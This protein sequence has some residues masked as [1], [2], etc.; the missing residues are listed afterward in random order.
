M[1]PHRRLSQLD[2]IAAQARA[3]RTGADDEDEVTRVPVEDLVESDDVE[4]V[5]S[6]EVVV[7]SD[8]IEIS[9]EPVWQANDAT[10][11]TPL[12]RQAHPTGPVIVAK[13]ATLGKVAVA[14]TPPS[15]EERKVETVPRFTIEPSGRIGVR[16]VPAAQ[17]ALEAKRGPEPT[18]PSHAGARRKVTDATRETPALD[19]DAKPS[20]RAPLVDADH[21]MTRVDLDSPG[22]KRQF[23]G[24][25]VARPV[26]SFPSVDEDTNEHEHDAFDEAAT[27]ADVP[28]IPAAKDKSVISRVVH[29]VV[30]AV[31]KAIKKAMDA[32][33]LHKVHPEG[34]PKEPTA[35]RPAPQPQ[36]INQRDWKELRTTA[37]FDGLPNEALRDALLTGELRVLRLGR[38]RLIPLDGAIGVIRAG[39]VAVGSFGADV[40]AEE[41]K[42]EDALRAAEV[43]AEKAG[44]KSKAEKAHK[45]E[46]KRRTDV[47]ALIQLADRN[48]AY[49]EEGDVV[50]TRVGA[51]RHASI[52]CYTTTPATV[53]VVGRG[54]ADLWKRIY[55]FMSDR[56]RRAAATTRARLEATDG[57]KALVADFFIRHGLSVSMT[58]RVRKIDSCIECG[59]CEQA[60]EDR[61]GAKRLSLN[62]RILGGLDFVDACH[63][64][65]DQRCVDPCNF[66]AISFDANRKEVLINEANCTGCTLCAVNC[67]YDAIEMYE[68]DHKPQLKLRLQKAGSLAFGD[69]AGRKARLRR[70]AQKCDHCAFYNDQACVSACPTGALIEV[71]PSDVVSQLPAEARASAK[72]GHDRTT[73]IHVGQLNTTEAFTRGLE[74]LPELGRARAKRTKILIGMWW[75]LGILSVLLGTAEI[76]LRKLL[77]Q[78]SAAFFIATR[79]EGIEPELALDKIDFRPGCELAVNFGYVGTF[80]MISGLVY[81]WRRR[82]GFMKNWGSLRAWFDWHVMTGVVGPA[83]I[84]MHSAAKLDNWVS[85]AFWSMIGT[86]VSGILGRYLSTEVPERA[87]TAMVETLEVDKELAALREAHAGVRVAD[88]WFEGYRRR[89]AQFERRLVGATKGN[90]KK[91]K[92]PTLWGAVVT[93][94]WYLKDDLGRGSR[95]RALMKALKAA[96]QGRGSRK[97]RKQAVRLAERLALL[98]RRR[99]LLPRLEPMFTH[100]KA[101]HVP[102][103]VILTIVA[104]IHI[105]LALRS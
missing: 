84:L 98:E 30:T 29:S 47:G 19:P 34:Q 103:S 68:L 71:L 56:F 39:Q 7:D 49:F 36:S 82:L 28:A 57:G 4:V 60:C 80:V 37:I 3:A 27:R 101:I 46:R 91:R 12:P 79:V 88:G 92:A 61:Y 16:H 22:V 99:V 20:R 74:K 87:S 11:E 81:V 41:R 44:D 24:P 100:W 66:D 64:C 40:L 21:D 17:V 13:G 104:G 65:T 96:V 95:R 15:K 55:P 35:A 53:Y 18:S 23:P 83:F 89:V 5:A 63:T 94:F 6:G 45:R 59:A 52:A 73:T 58:L 9:E 8:E 93:F 31:P 67:P 54:R 48:I 38:D 69:G 42:A 2:R 97:V 50:E 10:V 25:Q 76:V 62:G 32:T 1:V 33:G 78:W 77:P 102:M 14:K 86:V 105:A 72:A 90:H 70:I 43:A 85:L 75:T 26:A 51:E